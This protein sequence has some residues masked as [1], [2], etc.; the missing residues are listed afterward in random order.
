MDKCIQFLYIIK[1][2]RI[3]VIVSGGVGQQII[4]ELQK[5]W[6]IVIVY[7]FYFD[8]DKHLKWAK[9][10]TKIQDVFTDIKPLCEMFKTR[11]MTIVLNDLDRNQEALQIC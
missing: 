5:M 8:K 7:I 9:T 1:D 4:D 11:Y 2:E 3:F 10:Y 6:T